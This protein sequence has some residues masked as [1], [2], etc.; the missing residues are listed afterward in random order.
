MPLVRVRFWYRSTH[1]SFYWTHNG[2]CFLHEPRP[3]WRPGLR[4]LQRL[5][6]APRPRHRWKAEVLSFPAVPS[7]QANSEALKKPVLLFVSVK[8]CAVHLPCVIGTLTRS[9]PCVGHLGNR[10]ERPATTRKP[11]Y[12]SVPR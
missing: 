8:R 5:G 3:Y 4:V 12:M 7:S 11:K 1:N 9:F 2:R 10:K 6:V